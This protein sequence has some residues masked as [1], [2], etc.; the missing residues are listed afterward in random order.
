MKIIGHPMVV[1]GFARV[2]IPQA[3]MLPLG[4][5]ELACLALYL[6]PRTTVL[7]TVLLTG[8][9]GGATAVNIIGGTD[10]IHALVVGLVVWAGAWF[11]VP[12]LRSLIPFRKTKDA[13]VADDDRLEVR[14]RPAYGM[15]N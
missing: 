1:E 6:I 3:A 2:G 5:V 9:L 4:L 14:G 10:F 13:S 11:R 12:Q 15:D 7:G 8:Y